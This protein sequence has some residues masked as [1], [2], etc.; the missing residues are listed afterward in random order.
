MKG[1]VGSALGWMSARASVCTGNF[2][3]RLR[4]ACSAASFAEVVGERQGG[5]VI[6]AVGGGGDGGEVGCGEEAVVAMVAVVAGA[7]GLGVS[8]DVGAVTELRFLVLVESSRRLVV[9][10]VVAVVVAVEWG[11]R[12]WWGGSVRPFGCRIGSN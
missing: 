3:C 5:R 1:G 6:G 4:R 8:A 10:V 2:G 12:K 11:V 9:V 7:L